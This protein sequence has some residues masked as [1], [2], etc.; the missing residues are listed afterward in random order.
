MTIEEFCDENNIDL[1]NINDAQVSFFY[2]DKAQYVHT[3]NAHEKYLASIRESLT[4]YSS[5][6]LAEKISKVIGEKHIFSQIFMTLFLITII[7]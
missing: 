5:K 6:K 2:Y 3:S 4:S 7:I 1:E